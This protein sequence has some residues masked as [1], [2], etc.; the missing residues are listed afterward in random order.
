MNLFFFSLSLFFFYQQASVISCC[1]RAPIFI[2]GVFGTDIRN[3]SASPTVI[4]GEV[5][6]NN[7]CLGTFEVRKIKKIKQNKTQNKQNK[8][9]NKE[10][11]IK[12]NKN[13]NKKKT[14]TQHNIQ[15]GKQKENKAKGKTQT[16]NTHTQTSVVSYLPDWVSCLH[17]HPAVSRVPA[18][19]AVHRHTAIIVRTS[20]LENPKVGK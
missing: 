8:I 14:H 13:K 6:R 3:T 9:W 5:G 4:R 1:G 15:K 7:N 17:L 18:H 10:N 12:Q 19:V 20:L 16:Q 11:K 2:I